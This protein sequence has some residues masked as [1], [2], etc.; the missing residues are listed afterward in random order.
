MSCSDLARQ[1]VADSGYQGEEISFLANGTRWTKFD[2]LSEAV[3]ADMEAAGLNIDFQLLAWE[4][5]LYD[6]FLLPI[7][8]VGG[9]IFCR[10]SPISASTAALRI[11]AGP[12][13]TTTRPARR[14]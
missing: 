7:G 14:T 3:A 4:V 1:I 12:R 6:E 2:E 11:S 10:S 9:D 13:A 8:E 5:W